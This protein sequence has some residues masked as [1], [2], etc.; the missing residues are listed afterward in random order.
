VLRRLRNQ[1][2]SRALLAWRANAK[3]LGGARA[4]ARGALNRWLQKHMYRGL[5]A[6]RSSCVRVRYNKLAFRRW[7]RHTRVRASELAA[8]LSVFEKSVRRLR[9]WHVAK[10]WSRFVEIVTLQLRLVRALKRLRN[11]E[12]ARCVGT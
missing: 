7:V 3:E 2:S 10:G 12:L 11:V 6:W 9:M 5:L 4:T 1:H 8:G